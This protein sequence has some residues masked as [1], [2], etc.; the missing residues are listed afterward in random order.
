MDS[1]KNPRGLFLI[2]L[3]MWK[4]WS[5]LSIALEG[6]RAWPIISRWEE[7]AQ[8]ESMR[9]SKEQGHKIEMDYL[10]T[11]RGKRWE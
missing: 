6:M 10:P 1:G 3:G 7:K 9:L 5:E 11:Q 8:A 4:G 2:G